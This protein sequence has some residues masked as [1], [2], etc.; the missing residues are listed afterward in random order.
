VLVARQF[1]QD[2]AMQSREF[3]KIN[4]LCRVE[5]FERRECRLQT[6]DQPVCLVEFRIAQAGPRLGAMQ[7]GGLV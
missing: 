5:S 2:A 4:A 1:D 7:R 6:D 3:R